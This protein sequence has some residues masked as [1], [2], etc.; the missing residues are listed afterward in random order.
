M[1]IDNLG[2]FELV[3]RTHEDSAWKE[4]YQ[5]IKSM[6]IGKMRKEQIRKDYQK[7]I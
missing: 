7:E 5:P 4:A 3:D 2:V 1:A 6:P